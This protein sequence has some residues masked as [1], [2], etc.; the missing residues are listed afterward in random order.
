MIK[1]ARWLA[2]GT[3]CV[4][5]AA[6]Q[7]AR[8]QADD[9]PRFEVGAQFTA[10]VLED[11]GASETKAGAGARFTYNITNF[12]AA[13]AQVDFHPRDSPSFG[14]F[15][16]GRALSGLFGVKAGKR[17]ERFG[18]YGKV[19]PG[20]VT[21]G[22]G[23]ENYTLVP[24]P[25]AQAPFVFEVESRKSTEFATDVG[26]VVEFYPTRRIVT[27]FDIG[28]TIIKYKDRTVVVPSLGVGTPP[29]ITLTPVSRPGPTTH[30]FQFSAGVGFRF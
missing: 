20:F 13:E 1:K 28:D 29:P 3:L 7:Q 17:Y 27:R 30:N 14:D 4:F 5:F 26:A 23:I 9:P 10:I 18:V 24:T 2:L 11:D 16:G 22:R 6:R 12:L 15:T 21:F 19:R 25:P 8:A